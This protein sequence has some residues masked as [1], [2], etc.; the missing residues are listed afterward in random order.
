MNMPYTIVF[1]TTDAKGVLQTSVPEGATTGTLVIGV[2]GDDGPQTNVWTL[3][4]AF[5]DLDP[6]ETV[7]G[8]QARLANLGLYPAREDGQLDDGTKRA[9]H[10]FQTLEGLPIDLDAKLDQATADHLKNRYGS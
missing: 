5:Q 10:R 1:S 6:V 3:N 9:L 4:L 2:K 8:A 7:K